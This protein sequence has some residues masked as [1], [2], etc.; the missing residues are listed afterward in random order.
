[1]A[2]V[3][4]KIP[5]KIKRWAGEWKRGQEK[6]RP[7]EEVH[8][9]GAGVARAWRGVDRRGYG[10]RGWD[11]EDGNITARRLASIIFVVRLM[12][13]SFHKDFAKYQRAKKEEA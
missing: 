11:I 3:L 12:E 1:M 5:A 4:W 8:G 10:N 6:R 7:G 9:R 13:R 2:I